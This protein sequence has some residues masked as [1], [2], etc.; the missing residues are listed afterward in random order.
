M[1]KSDLVVVLMPINPSD[2]TNK[3]EVVAELT[4]KAGVTPVA[5][6]ALTDKTAEGLVVPMPILPSPVITILGVEAVVKAVKR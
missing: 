3:S 2:L 6:E 5:L 1:V 4:V